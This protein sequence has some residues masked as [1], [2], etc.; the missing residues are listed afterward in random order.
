MFY[1]WKKLRKFPTSTEYCNIKGLWVLE[2][3]KLWGEK[4]SWGFKDFC[5]QRVVVSHRRFLGFI[6][7]Y[8]HSFLNLNSS[9]RDNQKKFQNLLMFL[10]D[11]SPF[12]I[13][14]LPLISYFF[15]N[16]LV[17]V[18]PYAQ[19]KEG[20]DTYMLRCISSGS[21]SAGQRK[22]FILVSNKFPFHNKCDADLSQYLCDFGVFCTESSCPDCLTQLTNRKICT[23]F[24]CDVSRRCQIVLGQMVP[25]RG[26]HT[27][28]CAC[29]SYTTWR[30]WNTLQLHINFNPQHCHVLEWYGIFGIHWF[31][32]ML[33]HHRW[34]K[35][36]FI[37]SSKFCLL[38]HVTL[39]AAL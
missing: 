14:L 37:I 15:I 21:S 4:N 29:S 3:G 23:Y 30:K 36:N 11:F 5:N 38:W 33:D 10:W 22:Y 12:H 8:L 17:M 39:L 13:V 1:N 6:P 35:R 26:L 34:G 31:F 19:L 28:D 2:D 20:C 7:F 24:S 18:R 25:C 27:D 9:D 32:S 16:L